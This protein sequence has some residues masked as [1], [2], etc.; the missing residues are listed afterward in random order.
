MLNYFKQNRSKI[1]CDDV[2]G[3]PVVVCIDFGLPEDTGVVGVRQVGVR[4]CWFDWL[5]NWLIIDSQDFGAIQGSVKSNIQDQIKMDI[6]DW[7]VIGNK[8][9]K[10]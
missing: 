6:F 4:H 2:A 3:G 10:K 8:K 1:V 7:K 9:K 5:I